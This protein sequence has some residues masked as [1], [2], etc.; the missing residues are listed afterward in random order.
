[1]L[2]TKETPAAILQH[3]AK[4]HTPAK[5]AQSLRKGGKQEGKGTLELP[6]LLRWNPPATL[7]VLR[8]FVQPH[9]FFQEGKTKVEFH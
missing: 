2:E 1:M 8:V 9:L 6:V 7:S 5:A 4:L 3:K